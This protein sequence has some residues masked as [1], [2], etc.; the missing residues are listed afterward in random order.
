MLGFVLRRCAVVSVRESV[1]SKHAHGILGSA[2]PITEVPDLSLGILRGRPTR[3]GRS[4]EAGMK[5]SVTLVDW[6]EF[7]SRVRAD[8]VSAMAGFVE[9]LIGERGAEVHVVPQ[10][11]KAW[12]TAS[13]IIDDFLRAIRSEHRPKVNVIERGLDLIRCDLI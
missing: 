4:F 9:R 1:S 3:V 2:S 11:V 8:Y 7:G 5:V 13:F 10:V 12:E 6:S